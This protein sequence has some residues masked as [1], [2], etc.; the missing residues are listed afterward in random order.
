VSSAVSNDQGVFHS[1]RYQSATE[2]DTE[3]KIFRGGKERNEVKIFIEEYNA[4][5]ILVLAVVPH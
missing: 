3:T 1:C 4:G 2:G 5:D